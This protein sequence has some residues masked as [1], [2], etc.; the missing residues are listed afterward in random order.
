QMFN[1]VLRNLEALAAA[2]KGKEFNEDKIRARVFLYE[3]VALT[4]IE[5]GYTGKAEESLKMPLQ[6]TDE[7]LVAR[8]GDVGALGRRA[9]ILHLL[10]VIHTRRL[11]PMVAEKYFKEALQIREKLLGNEKVERFTPGKT[12]MDLADSLDALERWDAAIKMRHEAY[13]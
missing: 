4:Q 5:L 6:L 9:A 12:R 11:N 1:E 13:D 10:G 7:W 2:E 3:T 8:P